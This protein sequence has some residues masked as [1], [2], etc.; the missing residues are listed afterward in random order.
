VKKRERRTTPKTIAECEVGMIVRTAAGLLKVTMLL[1]GKPW[2][3]P[4]DPETLE[5]RCVPVRKLPDLAV[6]EVVRE[7]DP[8]RGR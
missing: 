5:E 4:V 8:V 2:G 1:A 3:C 6:E 7:F